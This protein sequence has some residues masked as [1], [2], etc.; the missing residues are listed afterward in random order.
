M[1][2]KINSEG[3]ALGVL[4]AFHEKADGIRKRYL[5]ADKIFAK[6]IKAP[7]I[8]HHIFGTIVDEVAIDDTIMDD[9]V[10]SDSEDYDDIDIS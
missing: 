7:L 5:R 6:Y 2:S 1:I 8:P 3:M 4:T 9:Y 10:L